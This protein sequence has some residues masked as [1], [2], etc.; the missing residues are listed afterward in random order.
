MLLILAFVNDPSSSDEDFDVLIIA[1]E[2]AYKHNDKY[3]LEVDLFN[4]WIVKVR[5]MLC[6]MHQV[7][8]NS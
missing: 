1:L 8:I 7:V 5:L 6:S 3:F 2:N 4:Q